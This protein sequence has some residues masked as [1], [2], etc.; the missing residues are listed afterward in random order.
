MP[1]GAAGVVPKWVWVDWCRLGQWWMVAHPF[2]NSYV[3]FLYLS[4]G[5]GRVEAATLPRPLGR[6]AKQIQYGKGEA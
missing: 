2:D 4:G 1:P 5:I 6:V 3:N